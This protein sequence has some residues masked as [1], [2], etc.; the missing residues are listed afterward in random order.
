MKCAKV[1]G[2]PS[3]NLPLEGMV[4]HAALEH[5]PLKRNDSNDVKMG[6]QGAAAPPPSDGD[7]CNE[8]PS[9]FGGAATPSS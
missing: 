9:D 7:P 1:K 3:Q 2:R 4:Q 6:P 8:S 5:T